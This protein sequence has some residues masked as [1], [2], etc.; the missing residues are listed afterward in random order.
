VKRKEFII[1][2]LIGTFSLS[3]KEPDD[4]GGVEESAEEK[5]LN[6]YLKKIES[7]FNRN[8]IVVENNDLFVG[9]KEIDR[10]DELEDFLKYFPFY[11]AG[12]EKYGVPW[13]LLWIIHLQES[14]VSR[15]P[16][17]ER[18]G[19]LG[20]MQR[21]GYFYN[22][23]F[24]R[25]SYRDWEFLNLLHQRYKKENGS[26]TSD[27]EEIMFAAKKIRIDANLIKTANLTLTDEE[28]MLLAQY[29]YCANFYAEKRIEAYKNIKKIFIKKR[30]MLPE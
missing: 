2:S 29:R 18:S 20:G 13:L 19:Y 12:E 11:K 14:G 26:R 5:K 27:F 15:H 8:R 10:S 1:H 6:I 4:K 28:S 25:D 22:D 16:N 30:I 23:E 3:F 9:F 17:P 7:E 24:I 21:N